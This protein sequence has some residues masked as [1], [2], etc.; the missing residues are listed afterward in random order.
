M[1][2]SI[3]I[4]PTTDADVLVNYND[5]LQAT[6]LSCVNRAAAPLLVR[7]VGWDDTGNEDVN[8]TYGKAFNPGTD[9][10]AISLATNK[11]ITIRN[12]A[13]GVLS[14]FNTYIG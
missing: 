10:V 13:K 7:I 11:A 5:A 2:G 8:R 12:N 3:N 6:S 9:S 4:S 1:A 14:G